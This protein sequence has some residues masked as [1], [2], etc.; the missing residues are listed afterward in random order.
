M[1]LRAASPS[2]AAIVTCPRVKDMSTPALFDLD[3]FVSA[4]AGI[5]ERACEELRAGRKATHSMWFVFPQM[6][7]LGR[8]GVA[9]DFGI[10]SIEEARAY[11]AHPVLGPRLEEVTRLVLDHTGAP[12]RQLFGTPDDL[13]FRS[14][15]TLFA[16][17]AGP[18]SVYAEAIEKLCGGVPDRRT[19]EMLEGR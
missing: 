11:L 13:K 17:A 6:R 4:Q 12:L 16:V 1:T 2:L 9:W 15:M 7:G 5:H 3:R 8:S 18:R 10:S 14:S 19:L